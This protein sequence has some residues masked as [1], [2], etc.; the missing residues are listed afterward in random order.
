MLTLAMLGGKA[1]ASWLVAAGVGVPLMLRFNTGIDFGNRNEEGCS[2][3]QKL[4]DFGVGGW[5]FAPSHR[6]TISVVSEANSTAPSSCPL[7]SR[8]GAVENLNDS[9]LLET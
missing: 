8:S 7:G 9:D 6:Q 3:A 5:T 1:K 4:R 2:P